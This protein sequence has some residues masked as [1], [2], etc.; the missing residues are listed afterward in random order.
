M[1]LP[2]LRLDILECIPIGGRFL[3]QPAHSLPFYQ[4]THQDYHHDNGQSNAQY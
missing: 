2:V 4:V 3:A 1:V